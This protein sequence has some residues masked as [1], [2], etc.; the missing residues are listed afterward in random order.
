MVIVLLKQY[1]DLQEEDYLYQYMAPKNYERW[2]K[3]RS[4]Q[5]ESRKATFKSLAGLHTVEQSE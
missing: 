2:S 5:I 1:M 4:L 3:P